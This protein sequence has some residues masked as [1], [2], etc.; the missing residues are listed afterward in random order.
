M[1]IFKGRPFIYGVLPVRPLTNVPAEALKVRLRL[2]PRD[3]G[4]AFVRFADRVER[5]IIEP[6]GDN[7]RLGILTGVNAHA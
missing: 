1:A 2:R 4:V 5:W 3:V 7:W 6:D